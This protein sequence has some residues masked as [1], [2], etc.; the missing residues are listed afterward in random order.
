M[1]DNYPPGYT[2]IPDDVM[3]EIADNDL[4]GIMRED[5]TLEEAEA[6][7]NYEEEYGEQQ[8]EDQYQNGY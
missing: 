7:A 3:E 8:F 4:N 5:P 6:K 1:S 2:E